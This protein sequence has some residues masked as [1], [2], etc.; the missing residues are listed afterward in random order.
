MSKNNQR[1]GARRNRRIQKGQYLKNETN[2]RKLAPKKVRREKRKL[3][4][5]ILKFK[6]KKQRQ[7]DKKKDMA[8][9]E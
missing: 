9:E 5:K 8:L 1:T 4:K 6:L 7:E 3:E 2:L